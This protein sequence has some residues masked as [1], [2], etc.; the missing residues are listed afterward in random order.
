M[1]KNIDAPER[2]QMTVWRMRISRWVRKAKNT[3]AHSEYVILIAFP[4]QQ[5]LY[6]RASLL[7]YT[8]VAGLDNFRNSR[9]SASV[10]PIWCNSFM[11]HL[12]YNSSK[13]R[14]KYEVVCYVLLGITIFVVP[15]ISLYPYIYFYPLSHRFSALLWHLHK[16]HNVDWEVDCE[17]L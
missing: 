16:L 11:F 6:E 14:W 17:R 10:C 15:H 9:K 7:R 8:Y 3:Q 13:N 2:P 1:W 12:P 4:L 5:W